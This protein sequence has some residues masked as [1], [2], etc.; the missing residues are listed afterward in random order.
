[1]NAV[2]AADSPTSLSAPAGGVLVLLFLKRSQFR[3]VLNILFL[4]RPK[5]ELRC[6][7]KRNRLSAKT[8]AEMPGACH[9]L[10]PTLTVDT[11]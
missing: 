10:V 5:E 3:M 8:S 4:K 11:P 2:V 6:G 9:S 7:S 1:M